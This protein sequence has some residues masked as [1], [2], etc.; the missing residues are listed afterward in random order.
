MIFSYSPTQLT[1][2]KFDE[3]AALEY[4]HDGCNPPI[5]HRDVKADNILLNE[6]M[7]AKV[8]YFGWSRRM[9][10]ENPSHLSTTFVVGTSGYL[11]PQ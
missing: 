2:V 7:Q 10:S 4:L 3:F 1:E 6:K 11:D 9:P 5:V 8:A